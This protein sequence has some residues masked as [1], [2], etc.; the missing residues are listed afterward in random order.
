LAEQRICLTLEGEPWKE[1]RAGY[2][3]FI[4]SFRKAKVAAGVKGVTF[5]DLRGTAVTRP[6]LA[7][8]TVPEICA[9]TGHSHEEA[10]ASCRRII[11]TAIRSS[12]GMPS[13]NWS[14][15]NRK[16]KRG[17]KAQSEAQAGLDQRRNP[18]NCRPR[19]EPRSLF[20]S[21][22]RRNRNKNN[23]LGHLD[24]NQD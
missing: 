24:S 14:C 1:G 4:A 21:G 20:R 22:K 16:E 2:N 7:G 8:C 17:Q 11:C 10:N 18:A 5:S 23:W 9:I 6:A 15:G 12:P 13:A 3:G 19:C